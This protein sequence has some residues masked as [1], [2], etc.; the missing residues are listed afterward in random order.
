M[1]EN[2]KTATLAQTITALAVSEQGRAGVEAFTLDSTS[3]G[4]APIGA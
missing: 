4:L 3:E 2:K 1:A